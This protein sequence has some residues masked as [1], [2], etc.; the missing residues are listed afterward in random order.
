MDIVLLVIECVV[1]NNNVDDDYND[2]DYYD[3]DIDH[4]FDHSNHSSYIIPSHFES[5]I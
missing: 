2:I 4:S 3:N 1:Y 5:R